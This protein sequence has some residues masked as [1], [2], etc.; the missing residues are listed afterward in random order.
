M[1]RGDDSREGAGGGQRNG[2]R[3]QAPGKTAATEGEYRQYRE[4]PRIRVHA[5]APVHPSARA[6]AEP[7]RQVRRTMGTCVALNR[8]GS[9][10]VRGR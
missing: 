10:I 4:I 9:S 8:A 2:E 5:A 7:A 3:R 1:S 6:A